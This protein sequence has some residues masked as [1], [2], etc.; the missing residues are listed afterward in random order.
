[1][2]IIIH[3]QTDMD[4]IHQFFNGES[5]DMFLDLF[6]ASIASSV[7]WKCNNIS[8]PFQEIIG[9]DYPEK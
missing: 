1:M 7:E 6:Y 9:K 5:L 2:R 8:L 4:L 3:S